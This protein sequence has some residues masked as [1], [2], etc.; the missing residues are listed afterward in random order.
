[1]KKFGDRLRA[2]REAAGLSQVAAAKAAGIP[3]AT[4]VEAETRSQ[5]PR[6]PERL[7]R[8]C[9]LLATDPAWLLGLTDVRRPWP[10]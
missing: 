3:H 9:D 4:W 6:D 2:A 10:P 7:R 5:V 1:M 8:I